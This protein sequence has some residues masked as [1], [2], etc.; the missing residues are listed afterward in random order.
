VLE[1]IRPAWASRAYPLAALVL[2]AVGVLA[3]E[4]G[5]LESSGAV[6]PWLLAQG[7]VAGASLLVAWRGQDHLSLVALLVIALAVRAAFL[8]IHSWRDVGHFDPDAHVY[9]TQGHALLHGDYPRSE[10]PTGAVLLFALDSW[11]GNVSARPMSILMVP[12]Q[13]LTVAGIWACRTRWSGCLAALVAVWPL[14]EYFREWRFDFAATALLVTGL[15][16]ALRGRFGLAGLLLG[17]GTAVK[18]TPGLAALT[19][20]VW[21]V[22]SGRLSAAGRHVQGFA[23]G[24]V[25]LT[26]PLLVWSPHDVLAAYSKQGGRGLMG[27]SLPYQPLRWLGFADRVTD[28]WQA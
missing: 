20:L 10:Y 17:V 8:G 12:F 5:R 23:W 6:Y 21:L 18:W 9:A 22:A 28:P 24:F 13:L 16:V 3:L 26:L 4:V 27:E 15:A 7:A 14:D 1:P 11:L 2:G 19:L 25:G